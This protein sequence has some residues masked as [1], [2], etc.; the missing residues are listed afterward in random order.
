LT[1]TSVAAK[2][3]GKIVYTA[4]S[5]TWALH[6]GCESA[7]NTCDVTG[8]AV[9]LDATAAVVSSTA[10]RFFTL[11]TATKGFPTSTAKTSA[12]TLSFYA[13]A[14]IALLLAALF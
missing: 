5:K 9:V 13:F 3:Y 8:L 6:F 14:L 2:G 10:T 1:S 11:A 4:S 12:A 7:C